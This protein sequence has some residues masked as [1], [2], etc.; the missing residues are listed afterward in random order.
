[1]IKRI[2]PLTGQA[3]IE[4]LPPE[5]VS[6]GGIEF[7]EWDM[8]PEEKQRDA[9]NPTMPRPHTG[10]VRAIGKWPKAK[11]GLQLMPEFGVGSKVILKHNAGLQMNRSIGE[12]YRMVLHEEVLAVIPK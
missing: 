9:R 6:A 10:I 2:K 3:F 7:P 11:N 12:K 8:T 4:I 1:M 5:S